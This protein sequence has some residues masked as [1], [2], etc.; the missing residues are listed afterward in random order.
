[1]GI[2]VNTPQKK[3]Y[4]DD[5]LLPTDSLP[6]MQRLLDLLASFCAIFGLTVNLDKTKCM[7]FCPP[8]GRGRAPLT[9]N[10]TYNGAPLTQ[11]AQLDYLGLTFDCKLGLYRSNEASALAKGRQALFALTAQL[12]RRRLRTPDFAR[13]LFDLLVDPAFSYGCQIWGPDKFVEALRDPMSVGLQRIPLEFARTFCGLGSSAHRLTLLREL[14]M[15]PVFH[16]WLCLA[17]R[18][19]NRLKGMD[20]KRLFRIAFDANVN[21]AL[22]GCTNCWV[23]RLLAALAELELAPATIAGLSAADLLALDLD[24]AALKDRLQTR[25]LDNWPADLGHPRE[26]P[27][28]G[29]LAATYARWVGMGPGAT[30]PH[31]HTSLPYMLRRVLVGFRVGAHSLEVVSGR[32]RGV[33]R[34]D[35]VCQV[36][37]HAEAHPPP[38]EDLMHFVLECPHYQS[39]R[40]AHPRVFAN[41][42]HAASAAE[43]V[44]AVFRCASQRELAEC[45][46]AMMVARTARLEQLELEAG[47]GQ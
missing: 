12:R 4:A 8:K 11:V 28:Q 33:A 16:H 5:I 35:R 43:Q 18:M 45:L 2:S 3:L 25:F 22:G 44:Q 21:L 23:G 32:F 31:L 9:L 41:A 6:E 26:A 36:H 39:I 40:D 19:W 30:P 27:S 29:V 14:G 15:F 47:G 42:V 13:R 46:Q 38:V 10:L 17:V 20:S 1:M 7:C 34:G 37:T 24:E